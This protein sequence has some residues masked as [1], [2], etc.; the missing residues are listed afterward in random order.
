MVE[1]YSELNKNITP[2][3]KRQKV[4]HLAAVLR[5]RSEGAALALFF[6]TL[7]KLQKF[8]VP[9]KILSLKVF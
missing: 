2:V 4:D 6:D 3:S 8:D 7:I 9:T 1:E 5:S